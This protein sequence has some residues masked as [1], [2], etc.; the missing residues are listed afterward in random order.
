MKLSSLYSAALVSFAAVAAVFEP[1]ASDDGKSAPA[2]L[3]DTPEVF[4][5]PYVR[6]FVVDGDPAKGIWRKAEPITAFIAKTGTG[7]VFRTEVRMM[8]SSKAFYICGT[9]HQ[10][11]ERLTAQFDQDDLAVYNDDCMEILLNTPNEGD[12]DFIYMAIN[13]LGKMLDM[14]NGDSSF[15]VKG[16]KVK[17]LRRADRW[18]FELKLPFAGFPVIEPFGGDAYGIRF[19]RTVHNPQFICTVPKMT[20]RSH[21]RKADFAKLLFMDR[22]DV[23]DAMRR[24]AAERKAKAEFNR[25]FELYE[26]VKCRADEL[27]GSL[28]GLDEGVKVFAEAK[29][30]AAQLKAAVDGFSARNA[31]ALSKKAMPPLSE[32]NALFAE[33]KG[34]EKY[35]EDRA[36]VMWPM[37][38]W[39]KGSPSDMPPA[40]YQPVTRISFEQ[41]GNER[42][43]VGFYFRSL[44]AGG[45]LDLR[46]SP[47]SV[48]VRGRP[49]SRHSFEI[50]EEKFLR[51]K[52]D[53]ISEPL[54]KVAGDFITLTPGVSTRV[55]IVFNSRGIRPGEY[56]TDIELKPAW[57]EDVA[58][59]NIEVD[60]KVWDFDL[61][62]TR[63]WPL[64]SFFWGPNQLQD[65]EAETVRLMHS[66][67]VTHGWTKGFLYW[68]GL[69]A[70]NRIKGN[71]PVKFNENLAKTANEE[72][73]R[74]AKDLGMRFVI[75]WSTP[76]CWQ[77]YKTMS[78]RFL[79]MGFE[80]E[81]FVFKSLIADEFSKKH[82]PARA[83]E[84][85][86]VT[87]NLGT[88]LWFQAVYLSTP[89]PSG[90]T[91]EDIEE[92]RLPEFYKFWTLI[93][94]L[95]HDKKRGAETVRRLRAKGCSVWDYHCGLHM[96]QR[97]SLKYYRNSP[98]KAFM[99]NLDGSA[100]WCSTNSKGNDSFD[101]SDGP[102]DG[103]LWLGN[104]RRFTTSK[105]FEAFREGLEDV[106]YLDRLR[107]ELKRH[108]ASGR[109]YPEYD[110]LDA[111]F[112]VHCK[113][114]D[115]AAIEAWRLAVGRAVDR[116]VKD[117]KKGKA[118]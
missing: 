89:P 17:T 115:Q 3:Y 65:D 14:K 77:W 118:K 73:F 8:Y 66:Y 94:D 113:N 81:D 52:D 86:A 105:N 62:E 24:A 117:V 71:D 34:F 116:L 39:S 54:V 78:E 15:R 110:K 1:I 23:T 90:A 98:R 80:Y 84:R 33:W 9:M 27:S 92:A 114:P 5:V 60:I 45:R 10:P 16:M 88:N 100:M 82:I 108:A 22:P 111:D 70:V 56:K 50:Y 38:M 79:G 103:I 51:Y 107:K 69:D 12:S 11:M 112:S 4:P 95:A 43:A 67:H 55:W 18:T 109:T 53:V 106:A 32:R 13:P 68:H 48:I 42:E 63:D 72:F 46:F 30:A 40:D 102:D 58:K 7:E 28:S 96:H 35:A 29:A 49:L 37:D 93:S 101:S 97:S 59:R 6:D 99:H 57:A 104:D 41:A 26:K 61:P 83:A 25:F 19:C 74:T 91:I 75:G 76:V 85:E 21:Y 44:L 36:Y 2:S 31:K 20:A 87:G 64:K 47:K